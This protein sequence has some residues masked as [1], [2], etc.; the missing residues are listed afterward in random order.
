MFNLTNTERLISAKNGTIQ[1][2]QGTLVNSDLTQ[3]GKWEIAGALAGYYWVVAVGAPVGGQYPWAVVSEPNG[4]SNFVL[5][6]D[7]KTYYATYAT[8]VA[9]VLQSQGFDKYWNKLRPTYQQ[10]NCVYSW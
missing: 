9:G 4:V 8:V 10:G 1:S 6:R 3:P 5:A 7:V 2:Y